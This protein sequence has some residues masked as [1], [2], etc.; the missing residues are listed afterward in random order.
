VWNEQWEP[1]VHRG[2]KPNTEA[3]NQAPDD[4]LELLRVLL[5][6]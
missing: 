1:L 6:K 2:R 4:L 5:W 3:K